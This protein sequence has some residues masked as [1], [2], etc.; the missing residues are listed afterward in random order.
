[1]NTPTASTC[2]YCHDSAAALAHVRQSGGVI[3]IAD[4][5]AADFTQRQNVVTVE[6]CAVCHGDGKT[7]DV[8]EVHEVE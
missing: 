5:D 6:S 8:S 4:P 3:S 1:V 2:Y 7:A